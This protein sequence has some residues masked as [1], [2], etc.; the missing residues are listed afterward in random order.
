MKGVEIMPSFN[1]KLI[2]EMRRDT[3]EKARRVL[4]DDER[5]QDLYQGKRT[6]EIINKFL[7]G[8]SIVENINPDLLDDNPNNHFHRIEGDKWDEFVG[9]IKEF[10]VI[11]PLIVR[12]APSGRYEILAGHNRKY[13]A[14][15]SGLKEV[16]CI[17]TDVDDVDASVIVGVTNNQRE[18]TTDLE[19]GWSYRTTYE[20][21]KNDHG[22]DRKSSSHDGNLKKNE[23]EGSSSHDGNLKEEGI[24]TLDIVAQKYGVGKNTVHRKIRLTYLTEQL[25]GALVKAK[26]PQGVMVDL[27]YLRPVDQANMASEI[28]WEGLIVTEE[29]AKSLKAMAQEKNGEDIGIDALYAFVRSAGTNKEKAPKR[30]KKYMVDESLFPKEVKKGERENYIVKALSYILDNNISV[31]GG[32]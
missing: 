14:I 27:S 3:E 18:E 31:M 28:A 2:E 23:E 24:K 6:E 16:P 8:K 22:G 20:A 32:E 7:D 30:P 9:S 10:G 12:K 1:K 19:W 11:T 21:L 15:E 5:V 13:G 25:Y 4:S 26:A 17:V 29:L